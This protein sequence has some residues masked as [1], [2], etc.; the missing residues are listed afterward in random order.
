MQDP[1]SGAVSQVSGSLVALCGL[2]GMPV[3]RLRAALPESLLEGTLEQAVGRANGL[4]PAA[5]RDATAGWRR[6]LRAL[7]GGTAAGGKGTRAPRD[8]GYT[9]GSLLRAPLGPKRKG[10]AAVLGG[11]AAATDGGRSVVPSLR[12]SASDV[13]GKFQRIPSSIPKA[14]A[15]GRAISRKGSRIVVGG[16]S[17]SGRGGN[18]S[19]VAAGFEAATALAGTGQSRLHRG[20]AGGPAAADNSSPLAA[21]MRSVVAPIAASATF[22]DRSRRGVGATSAG[23]DCSMVD[24]AEGD[25]MFVGATQVR[26]DELCDAALCLQSVARFFFAYLDDSSLF[27][28]CVSCHLI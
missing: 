27:R 23:G 19:G 16:V 4:S 8:Y 17:R 9:D 12:T 3:I 6:A 28:S 1:L 10:A 25:Q 15:F 13:G 26:I 21:P 2:I 24:Q 7:Y 14:G 5:L 22:R 11:A 18:D 20:S